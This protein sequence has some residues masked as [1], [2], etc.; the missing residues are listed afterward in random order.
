MTDRDCVPQ[1]VV[2]GRVAL[3]SAIEPSNFYMSKAGD[4]F[5]FFLDD[6]DD[7]DFETKVA[8]PLD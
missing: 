2:K 3:N 4:P 7:D 8:G 6:D 1:P 5:D